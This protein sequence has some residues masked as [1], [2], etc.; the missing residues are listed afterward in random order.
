MNAIVMGGV[1]ALV[2]M[3]TMIGI[4]YAL[5]AVLLLFGWK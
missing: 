1:A 5:A 2:V 3:A 4:A